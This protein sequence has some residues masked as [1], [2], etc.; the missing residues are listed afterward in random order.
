MPKST[1]LLILSD[2][3]F[4]KSDFQEFRRVDDVLSDEAKNEVKDGLIA[5]I[6]DKGIDAIIVSGDITSEGQP[7]EFNGGIEAVYYIADKIGIKKDDVF[8]VFGNHDVN[9]DISKLKDTK[10]D[11]GYLKIAGSVP[12]IYIENKNCIERGPVIGA[13]V[14]NREYATIFI[15]NSS[16]FSVHSQ[17]YN[18]G[19]LG[20]DQLFWLKESLETHKKEGTCNILLMHHHPYKYS[21]PSPTE[22]ISCVEEGSE[23]IDLLSGFGIDL[24]CH[25]HRHHPKIITRIDNGWKSPIT[26]LCAGSLSIGSQERMLGQIPNLFHVIQFHGRNQETGAAFGLV[27]NYEHQIGLGWVPLKSSHAC[28]GLDDKKWF[29]STKGKDELEDVVKDIIQNT[30]D[31]SIDNHYLMEH[32]DLPLELKCLKYEQLNEIFEK[33]SRICFDKGLIGKYPERVVIER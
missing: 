3:H 10:C 14:Y 16:F 32:T 18:H 23:L 24:I 29:G 26:F 4:G 9:W 2:I 33:V 11:D 31:K 6:K 1:N 7:K 25:G 19:K 30:F 17:E 5:K 13:G 22:D 27:E 21:F 28:D 8:F 12:S 15:L 20:E